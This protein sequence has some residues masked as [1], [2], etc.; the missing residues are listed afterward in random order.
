MTK[1]RAT[2]EFSECRACSLLDHPLGTQSYVSQTR[3]DED[4]LR[5]AIIPLVGNYGRYSYRRIT[6]LLPTSGW[7]V[8]AGRV[9]RIWRWEGLKVPQKQ[10]PRGYLWLNDGSCIWLRPE[11]RSHV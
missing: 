5:P 2:Y 9:Q 1:I 10:R 7:E 4:E 8:S 6:A 3:P 11:P